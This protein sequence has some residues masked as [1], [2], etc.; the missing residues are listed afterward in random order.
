MNDAAIHSLLFSKMLIAGKLDE[1]LYHELAKRY[2]SAMS[3]MEGRK[4]GPT[5]ILGKLSPPGRASDS[6]KTSIW[7]C[8]LK[9]YAKCNMSRTGKSCIRCQICLIYG[10]GSQRC[11]ILEPKFFI[12]LF[13][14]TPSKV[15]LSPD[16]I[17]IR[18]GSPLLARCIFYWNRLK[19]FDVRQRAPCYTMLRH[20]ACKR[21]T[22]GIMCVH[23]QYNWHCSTHCDTSIHF[24]RQESNIRIW[25]L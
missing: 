11:I 4:P 6:Q 13:F 2:V 17:I 14:L 15:Q 8:R 19:L 20:K 9:P 25:G 5:S 21:I 12:Y 16:H 3:D 7:S 10:T 23:N 18:L 1:D 24:S 22:H